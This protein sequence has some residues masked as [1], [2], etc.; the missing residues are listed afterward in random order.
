MI[1]IICYVH[2]C[3]VFRHS[4]WPH[5]NRPPG[6]FWLCDTPVENHCFPARCGWRLLSPLNASIVPL[7]LLLF[8]FAQRSGLDCADLLHRMYLH[9]GKISLCSGS[10]VQSI[11]KRGLCLAP[12]QTWLSAQIWTRNGEFL[13]VSASCTSHVIPRLRTQIS[14]S[15]R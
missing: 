4:L 9:N 10:L 3:I 6:Q 15:K 14:V 11:M 5:Q 7:P 1:R 2:F 12:C 8:T 13:L